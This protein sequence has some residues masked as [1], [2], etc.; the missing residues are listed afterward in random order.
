MILSALL[1][2]MIAGLRSMT[3][4][5]AVAWAAHAG[6][7]DV[8]STWAAF[9]GAAW[10]RWIFTLSAIGELVADKLP[11]TPS[12]KEPI[13]FGAR[14][15]SGSLCGAAIGATTDATVV[16][17]V[18]GV[19]G[20]VV[21]TLGGHALRVRL[22]AAFGKDRPAALVEDAI[23]LGGTVVVLALFR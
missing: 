9:L 21:G 18:A 20:A 16:G 4:P 19:V 3:A 15:A 10:T 11:S 12:R 5:A 22:A 13:G 6:A 23:A 7:L 14:I 8:A 17:L 1:I 2:G